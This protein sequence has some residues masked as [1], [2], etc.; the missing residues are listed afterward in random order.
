LRESRTLD[1]NQRL[2][3]RAVHHVESVLRR[4]ELLA[5]DHFVLLEHREERAC[6]ERERL[7]VVLQLRELCIG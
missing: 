3:S 1:R 7:D 2:S 5:R 4:L 6:E